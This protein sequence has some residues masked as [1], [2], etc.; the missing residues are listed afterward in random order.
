MYLLP[1]TFT[2]DSN[3]KLDHNLNS[4]C[5]E[6]NEI[7]ASQEERTWTQPLIKFLK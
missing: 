4:I 6:I 5:L 3:K 7:E 1:F 2:I